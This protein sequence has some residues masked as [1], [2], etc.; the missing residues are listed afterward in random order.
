MCTCSNK[1]AILELSWFDTKYIETCRPIF[2]NRF[3]IFFAIII[4]F[5]NPV[6]YNLT[7]WGHMSLVRPWLHGWY[8]KVMSTVL[9]TDI[10]FWVWIFR[11]LNVEIYIFVAFTFLFL[12]LSLSIPMLSYSILM[13]SNDLKRACRRFFFCALLSNF[14]FYSPSFLYSKKED[15]K[16]PYP[17]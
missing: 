13:T 6:L 17:G 16:V 11:L 10:K 8:H 15:L 5:Q 9:N 1:R 14:P 3:L 7:L 12:L 2:K 4:T